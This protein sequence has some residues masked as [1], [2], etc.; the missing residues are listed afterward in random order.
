MKEYY[1]I[2]FGK[3][4]L[5]ATWSEFDEAKTT[6]DEFNLLI[7]VNGKMRGTILVPRNISKERAVEK[8]Q[9]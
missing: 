6:E 8:I 9:S 1:E 3:E 2:V 5:D 4:I 7:Q